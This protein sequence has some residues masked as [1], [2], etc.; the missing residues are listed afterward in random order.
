MEFRQL[1]YFVTVANKRSYSL[2]AKELFVTQPTLTLAIKKLE[3]EFNTTL[4]EQNNR[5]LELTESGQML[6]EKGIVLLKSYNNLID[7]MSASSEESREVLKV[8]LTVLFAIQYMEEI[9]S[10]IARHPKVELSLIQHGSI[11]LQR[12]VA[13]GDLDLGLLC[14][15]Q[16]E[17]G[18]VMKPIERKKASYVAAIVV[19]SNHPLE[20]KKEITIEDLKDVRISSLTKNYVLGNE[21]YVKCRERGFEPNIVFSDDNW[22]VLVKSIEIFDSVAILPAEFEDISQFQNTKWI[23]LAEKMEYKVGIAHKKDEDISEIGKLFI[24]YI[25]SEKIKKK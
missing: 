6:Y 19:P 20:N 13:N 21:I 17:R 8:G 25:L 9:S 16:Y 5:R 3:K 11:Q 7:E 23:P 10:F 4:F 2:A 22:T 14:F 15:P 24:D 18:I 12:M 1:N